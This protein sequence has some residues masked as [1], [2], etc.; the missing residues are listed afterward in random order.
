MSQQLTASE[1]L[2][3]QS[4]L[5]RALKEIKTYEAEKACEKIMFMIL[6]EKTKLLEK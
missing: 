5:D 4:L 6:I 1:L 3:K 2:P